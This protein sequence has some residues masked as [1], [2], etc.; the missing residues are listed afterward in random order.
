LNSSKGL[1]RR[2][3][4]LNELLWWS[5]WATLRRRGDGYLL[6]S[7]ELRESFFNRAQSLTCHGL[8]GIAS[9]AERHFTSRGM[10]STILAFESCGADSLLASGYR[11]V[12]EM[13]VLHSAEVIADV[14]THHDVTSLSDPQAWTRA[15]LSSFYGD[16]KLAAVVLP[17]VTSLMESKGVT[18]LETRIGKEIA[19]V[20]ALFRTKG[21][22]GVYC[23][24]TSPKFRRRGV[25]TALL[26]RAR[27]IADAEG[28]AL[29]LQTLASDRAMK[30]YRARGFAKVHSKVVLEKKAQMPSDG[31]F[32]SVGYGV[33][34]D[35]KA[36]LGKHAFKS[37]F[38]GFERVDAVR[39]LFGKR[40]DHVLDKLPVEV[41]R[42]RGYMRINDGMGSIVVSSNYLKTGREIDIYLD[43]IHELV[44][45]RQHTEGKELW[46]R[47]YE[48]IDRP[49]EIE[50]YRVAVKEA[51]RLGMEEREVAEY[52]KVEW[53]SDEAFERFLK[54]CGVK[55]NI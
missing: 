30:F 50:A 54:N 20:S 47:T 52:L 51:R 23:L 12:D 2:S 35:R 10:S 24:G 18:L 16:E 17:K 9:W 32:H 26:A 11:K 53:I 8:A 27:K 6:S 7:D 43:V 41:I 19:G 22:A 29:V 28:R 21:I 31:T 1:D 39:R 40:T 49:T 3:L 37:V 44:H 5:R 45:I 46:D 25:A 33:K 36:K 4:E 14:G 34:I 48:Y 55:A 13:T 42:R 15:Y 38:E